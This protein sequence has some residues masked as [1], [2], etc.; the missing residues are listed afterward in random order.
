MVSLGGT[1]AYT[2]TYLYLP[3]GTPYELLRR[4]GGTISRYWYE[5]DGRGNVAALTD[6]AGNVV[7]RYHYDVWGVPSFDLETVPQPLLYAG[8][9]Y[10]RELGWY[11]LS[12]REY[13]PTL[14]RFLQTD[15]S[16]IEGVRSYAY[17]GDDPVDS[18]DP[19]GTDCG[20]FIIGGL[21]CGL[22]AFAQ[23]LGAFATGAYNLVAGDDIATLRNEHASGAEKFLAALDLASNALTLVPI[24]GEGV[25]AARLATKAALAVGRKVVVHELS[26]DEARQLVGRLARK[27]SAAVAKVCARCFPADTLVA[28]PQGE[29]AI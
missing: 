18:I 14:R 8:Y 29:R 19:N 28:T 6:K 23:G 11:W 22:T 4:Q 24:L 26:W 16:E 3:G 12:A 17:A 5:T 20:T 21:V 27:G 1:V 15:P 2:D 10:D 25:A 7:D 9:R 13:D